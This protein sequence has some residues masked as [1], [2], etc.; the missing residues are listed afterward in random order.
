MMKKEDVIIVADDD[1][2]KVRTTSQNRWTRNTVYWAIGPQ[3][4][5]FQLSPHIARE[6]WSGRI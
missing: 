3:D 1:D 2:D 4:S 6:V 5:F